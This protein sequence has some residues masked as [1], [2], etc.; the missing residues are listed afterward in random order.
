[1]QEFL[2]S[3]RICPRQCGAD[4]YENPGACGAGAEV[5]VAKA[6]LHQWEEPCISGGRGSGTV[7]FSGCN[8]NCV[9]CQNHIISQPTSGYPSGKAVS[10]D[11]LS[12]IFIELQEKGAHNINLVSPTPY[13]FHI[14][15][16]VR[17]A[18][19]NGLS[20][21]VIYNT[22]GYE[23]P[24]TIEAL[25]GTVDVYLPDLKYYGDSY[26]RRYSGVRNYFDKASEAIKVMHDQAGYPVF[27]D[28]GIIRKGLIIRHLLLP[29]LGSDSKE[30]FKWI[31]KNIGKYAYVSI[32]CQYT[33]MYKASEHEEINR[34]ISSA[35]YDKALDHF[36]EAGLENGFT[37]EPESASSEYTPVFD[38][39]GI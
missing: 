7:F 29:G 26:S 35:E 14:I 2:K 24:E 4:R 37:Q 12:E 21:P 34:G 17:K 36:F 19:L 28:E 3:C 10:T 15:E 23:K 27:D 25:K 1:M 20:L 22:N 30:V 31:R 16:A 39:S 13:A 32:M 5:I 11:R 38:L 8:M 9:F 18:K 6:F 33:P